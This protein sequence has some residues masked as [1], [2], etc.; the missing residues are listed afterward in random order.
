MAMTKIN[1]LGKSWMISE[2]PLGTVLAQPKHLEGVRVYEKTVI[3][4]PIPIPKMLKK[5]IQAGRDRGFTLDVSVLTARPP[6][7]GP[8]WPGWLSEKATPPDSPTKAKEFEDKQE[9]ANEARSIS[10]RDPAFIISSGMSG[11]FIRP[12]EELSDEQSR[13]FRDAI[14]AIKEDDV[15]AR[16]PG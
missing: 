8:P 12:V 16:S 4:D 15:P 10:P 7:D 11:K 5:A 3:S 6:R 14:Q 1:A 13:K 2:H 9:L